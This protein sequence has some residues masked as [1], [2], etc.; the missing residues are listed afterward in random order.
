MNRAKELWQKLEQKA[1]SV[2]K[3]WFWL[4]FLVFLLRLPSLFEPYWYGDEGIYL[5]IGQGLRQGLVLYRDIYDNKPPLIYFLAALSGNLFWFKFILLAW[6][7]VTVVFFGKIAK[8]FFP[9]KEKT[10]FFLTIVFAV[11]ISLP[12]LEGNI[13]NAENFFIGLIIAGGWFFWREDYKKAGLLMGLAFLFKF[14]PIFDFLALLFFTFLL[15][16]DK[17]DLKDKWKRTVLPLLEY[18][19]LP[20]FVTIIYSILRGNFIQYIESAILSNFSYT[21]SW[22]GGAFSPLGLVSRGIILCL[23]LIMF[24]KGRQ[25]WNDQ[26]KLFLSLWLTLALFGA[27]LSSRPYPHYLLQIIAPFILLAGSIFSQKKNLWVRRNWFLA[28]PLFLSLSAFFAYGFSFYRLGSYYQNFWELAVG[29]KDKPA[30]FSW[31]DPRVNQSYAL[32]SQVLEKTPP[33]E[34]IFVWGDNPNIYALSRHLPVTR[35]TVAYHVVEKKA[36]RETIQA[37]KEK[38][39]RLIIVLENSPYFPELMAYLREDYLFLGQEYEGQ[40]WYQRK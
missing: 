24:W 16:K 28:L 33:K 31:F 11:L 8:V 35:F 13:A 37:L 20:F 15:A 36:Y 12:A 14:P 10:A 19:F 2:P 30:Y 25:G 17:N 6:S 34:R 26:K 7:M 9:K 38:R 3:R 40:I 1:E 32:A 29:K 23:L 27:L 22:G 39:P 21:L 18:F 5:T 4:L